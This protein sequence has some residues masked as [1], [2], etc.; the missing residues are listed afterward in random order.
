[1]LHVCHTL[2]T[3]DINM[4]IL[5]V[6]ITTVCCNVYYEMKLFVIHACKGFPFTLCSDSKRAKLLIIFI[7]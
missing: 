6:T 3:H 7:W 1:M 4:D 5:I 2:A